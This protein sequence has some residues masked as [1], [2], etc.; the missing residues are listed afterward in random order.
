MKL[1]LKRIKQLI[2]EELRSSIDESTD[3]TISEMFFNIKSWGE[4]R[5]RWTFKSALPAWLELPSS[6][7]E[8]EEKAR[9]MGKTPEQLEQALI[10]MAE[11]YDY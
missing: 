5:G 7:Q 8:F 6:K 9:E 2:K 4:E 10:E 3:D 11:D 1:T